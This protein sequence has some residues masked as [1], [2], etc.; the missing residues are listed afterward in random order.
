[1]WK[2]KVRMLSSQRLFGLIFGGYIEAVDMVKIMT[3][4]LM[5]VK[6]IMIMV[7]I[8]IMIRTK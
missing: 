7:M 2:S 5:T 6:K 1:M 3:I 8:M 4:L